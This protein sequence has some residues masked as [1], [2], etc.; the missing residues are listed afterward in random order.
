MI[1]FASVRAHTHTHTRTYAYQ[2]CQSLC[3]AHIYNHQRVVYRYILYI[4]IGSPTRFA[5]FVLLCAKAVHD[6]SSIRSDTTALLSTTTALK[7]LTPCRGFISL[8]LGVNGQFLFFFLPFILSVSA[9]RGENTR[10]IMH[11]SQKSMRQENAIRHRP[12]I[13]RGA[14]AL[15]LLSLAW[16]H[17]ENNRQAIEHSDNKRA[18]H[19]EP[20]HR[21]ASSSGL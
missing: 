1:N 17:V 5:D 7:P 10:Y 20:V 6:S 8:A 12:W 3:Y 2:I 16:K 11:V 18:G 15:A 21:G 14:N 4:Y 13:R 19:V 9:I